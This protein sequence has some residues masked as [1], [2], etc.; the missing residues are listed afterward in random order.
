LASDPSL[1]REVPSNAGKEILIEAM[2]RAIPTYAMA[3]FDL[4]KALCDSIYKMVCSYWWFHHDNE[5]RIHWIGWEKMT[6]PKSYG[7]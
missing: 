6:L 3:C 7:G 2:A 5:N 1:E 4:T